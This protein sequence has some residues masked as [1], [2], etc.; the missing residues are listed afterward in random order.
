MHASPDGKLIAC[1]VQ[2]SDRPGRPYARLWMMDAATQKMW[3]VGGD[4]ASSPTWSP[5][6]QSVAFLG[7][8][9]ERSGLMIARPDGS[10]LRFIA[11]VR[12]TNHPLPSSGADLAWSPDGRQIAFISATDGPEADANGDPMVI[13]RYLYKPTAAEGSTRFNDNRRLHIFVAEVASQAVRQLT[14]GN[15]YEH[16]IDW[17]PR[18]DEILFVSNR[19]PDPDRFFNYD[20]FAVKVADGSRA[21]AHRHEERRVPARLVAGRAADR[22]PGDDTRPSRRPRRPW[23]TRT[24]G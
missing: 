19:E 23:R 8:D 6:G 12:G 11:P 14:T 3:R 20:V 1:S 21:A 10:G 7:T 2:S 22:L 15:Y 17:S 5:D 16:S 4:R 24:S 9:G 18:G 13:T